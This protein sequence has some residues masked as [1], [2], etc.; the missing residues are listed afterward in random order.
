MVDSTV[1]EDLLVMIVIILRVRSDKLQKE[2][3]DSAKGES[4]TSDKFPALRQNP[5]SIRFVDDFEGHR[6][7]S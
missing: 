6:F 3:K 7:K 1:Y 2:K 4:Y 5:G